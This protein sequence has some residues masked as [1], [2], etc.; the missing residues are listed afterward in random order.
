MK[1][2]N[3]IRRNCPPRH[4]CHPGAAGPSARQPAGS[5][6]TTT[7]GLN[8]SATVTLNG[9]VAAV[10]VASASQYPTI[11]LNGTVVK[12]APVW[13]LLEN[14][15]EI[16]TG[17][18]LVVRAAPALL[19]TGYYYALEVENLTTQKSIQLRDASGRPLWFPGPGLEMG[20]RG[21]SPG[22]SSGA[23]GA[24]A[25]QARAA[26]TYG[27][28][29]ET[30]N[31]V[32]ITGQIVEIDATAGIR[33]PAIVLDVGGKLVTVRIGPLRVLFATDL[34]L[35][36]GDVVSVIAAQETCTGN[37]VALELSVGDQTVQLRN[38][39]GS[40]AW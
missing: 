35:A 14:D 6:N 22:S 28:C 32:E 20:L 40:P 39:D 34:E 15:F 17:H 25:W 16:E 3:E 36:P 18:Q 7:A 38:P 9:T 5:P 23:A 8:L 26:V 27:G 1:T 24:F 30:N 2:F 10:N 29:L 31:L 37:F 21:Q 4:G 13:F 11:T 19:P 33:Q 12:V